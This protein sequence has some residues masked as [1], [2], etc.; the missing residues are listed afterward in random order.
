MPSKT[1]FSK[2]I[3]SIL[4]LAFLVL[5]SFLP[6]FAHEET[7]DSTDTDIAVEGKLNVRSA[8]T[9]TIKVMVKYP[10]TLANKKLIMEIFL[11]DLVTN[12]PITGT[13]IIA[14]FNYLSEKENNNLELQKPIFATALPTEEQGNYLAEVVFPKTGKYKLTLLMSKQ[15]LDA[16]VIITNII[17]PEQ[18]PKPVEN[19]LIEKPNNAKITV[20]GIVLFLS[21]IFLIIVLI[22]Y[23]KNSLKI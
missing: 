6:V 20:L 11:N 10:T 18:I 14:I 9:S 1:I 21:S 3:S 7:N 5:V 13:N 19:Q 4:L 12:D 17:I 15:K 2:P 22:K 8:K 23:F 16:Q